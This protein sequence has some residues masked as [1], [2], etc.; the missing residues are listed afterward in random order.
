MNEKTEFKLNT[1]IQICYFLECESMNT[2]LIEKQINN[3]LDKDNKE[4]KSAIKEL[5][6]EQIFF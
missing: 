3:I 1:L 5:K 6:E 2:F 4:F